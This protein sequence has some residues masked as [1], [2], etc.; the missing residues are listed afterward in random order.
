MKNPIPHL[1][2]SRVKYT[3]GIIK[4]DLKRPAFVKFAIHLRKIAS[5][6]LALYIEVRRTSASTGA[7][8]SAGAAVMRTALV[9]VH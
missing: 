3:D 2:K 6:V 1:R 8:G 7:V 9:E 5:K 4:Q